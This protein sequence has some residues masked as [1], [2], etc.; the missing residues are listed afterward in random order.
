VITLQVDA[1]LPW[2][3]VGMK[4]IWPQYIAQHKILVSHHLETRT[5]CGG[6]GEP[7]H[8]MKN[9]EECGRADRAI[10][11]IPVSLPTSHE[12]QIIA[13]GASENK[14]Y[15]KGGIINY[16]V[17][18]STSLQVRDTACACYRYSL[19]TRDTGEFVPTYRI[20]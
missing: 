14:L 10:Y 15:Q 11:R 9:M 2:E 8:F 12:E 19:K 6:G 1:Y 18:I 17:E 7:S 4:G 20:R 5:L 13:Q 16:M 3:F